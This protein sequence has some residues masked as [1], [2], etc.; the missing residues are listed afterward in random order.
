MLISPKITISKYKLFMS[1][2]GGGKL[3]GVP[4]NRT[5]DPTEARGD[6][7]DARRWRQRGRGSL[8]RVL[9]FPNN[10]LLDIQNGEH[11]SDSS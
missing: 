5:A 7:S 3:G 9:A 6:R 1:A 8:G 11:H 4:T 10:R 2:E